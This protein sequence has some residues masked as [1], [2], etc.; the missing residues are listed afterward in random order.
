[1]VLHL[2][3]EFNTHL[4]FYD[5]HNYVFSCY[6]HLDDVWKQ[7][8]ACGVKMLGLVNI[9]MLVKRLSA[10]IQSNRRCILHSIKQ[11]NVHTSK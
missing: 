4:R 3:K 9:G 1:M 7:S 2:K 5:L 8:V 11:I 10:K 6:L